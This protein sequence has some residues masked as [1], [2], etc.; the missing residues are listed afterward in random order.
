MSLRTLLRI[1]REH[2][3]LPAKATVIV[4]VSGGTDSLALL[5]MLN[6]LRN[7][8]EIS[9][10][11]ATFDHGLRPDS[12]DDVRFVHTVATELGLPCTA[13][14]ADVSTVAKETGEG[15]EL[16]ARQAR[17]AFLSGVARE[18]GADRIAVGHH[19]GDQAETMLM[20]IL[21]GTGMP[22]LQGMRFEAPVPN[23]PDLRLV[24]PLL[25][26]PRT[27]LTSYCQQHDLYPRQDSSNTDEQYSR[28]YIRRKV[29][30]FLK[31]VNPKV[32]QALIRL[33]EITSVDQDYLE[34]E[35]ARCV[36]P[37]I[38]REQGCVRIDRETF[39]SLH[40]AMRRRF[41]HRTARE[42]GY[43]GFGQVHILHAAEVGLHG[44]TGAVAQLPHGLQM[45]VA[46][47]SLI[48]EDADAPVQESGY[49]LLPRETT[50]IPV[51]FP[52]ITTVPNADWSLRIDIGE[53][54]DA[55][56]QMVISPDCRALLRS[57][58]PGDRFAPAGMSG[59]TQSVKKWMINR[60]IPRHLRNRVPLLVLDEVIAAILIGEQWVISDKAGSAN[61]E[62]TGSVV[63]LSI[64]G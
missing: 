35:Y 36:L 26:I 17:Y 62:T 2:N 27:A 11:V 30:P 31:S 3:L 52:G 57:R 10:H 45:R 1:V 7:H 6:S 14:Q 51:R 22:G 48:L 15:I 24:R 13:G 23:A 9:L 25:T 8:L 42:L 28:N 16:A 29:L 40:L 41:I 32:E 5:H 38:S 19:A 39:R 12:A 37:H 43:E 46:Y 59:K 50:E 18:I 58:H 53:H 47:D 60:K 56:A 20:H 55:S 54:Q 44:D 21:R 64:T 34:S 4:A 49:T 61:R 33:A 63:S